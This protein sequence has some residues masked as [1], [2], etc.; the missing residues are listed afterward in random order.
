MGGMQWKR[1]EETV[2][3]A[4]WTAVLLVLGCE[5]GWGQN[6]QSQRPSQSSPSDLTQVSIE[7]LMNMEV[8]SVSKKEQKLSEV[9]AAIFVITPEDIRHSGATNIPDLLRM[10]PGLNVAQID[11]NTW[12][13]SARGFNFQ[14]AS[15]LL[16]LIDG[17]AVYT[18]LFGGVNWDTQNVPLEDIERIEVIRG[19]GGAV[20]GANAVNGVIN[21]I[22]KKA[23]ET[24]GVLVTGGGGTQALEFGTVQ[25]GGKITGNTNYRIFTSYQ[26][27]NHLPD[28]NGQNGEDDWHLLHG[29][30]RADTKL[31]QKDTLTTQGDM[32]TG[33]EGAI[34]VHAVFSPPDNVNVEK[35]VPLSGG[36]ILGRWNHIFSSRCDTTLQLYF[37]RYRRRGPNS[38]E[39]QDTIDFDFQNHVVLGRRQDLIWGAGFRH[40]SD[41]T[42]GTV[43]EAFVPAES[44]KQFFSLFLQDQITLKPSRIYLYVGTK[45]EDSYFTGFD[46][47][48]SVH[49]AW[50]PSAHRT[51]WAGISRASRTP[52]RRDVELDAALA[53]LPGPAELV[54]LGNPK[55]KSEHVIAYELGYRGQPTERF[56]IDVTAF[57]NTYHD[58]QSAD[59]LPPFIAPGSVPPLLVL[60]LLLDNKLH[61]T[62]DGVEAFIRWKVANHWTVS[63]GYSFLQMR[64][65]ND[66]TS[67]NT[68]SVAH[69]EASNP[70][71]QAQLR[72]HLELWRGFAWD[73]NAYFV[74]GLPAQMVASY[75][76]LDTQLTW[77]PMESVSLSVVGQNLLRD[78][79]VEF[80]DSFQS[81]NSSQ[82][83]RGAYAKLTWQF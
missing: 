9:A 67:F 17:R 13:I 32:Y 71:H 24:P 77:R 44:T 62:T 28:L 50:T 20:W 26:N 22:T 55:M 30:F 60:P 47:Q 53:A 83:K 46:L 54:L 68:T 7:N 64:L 42:E 43:D 73:A 10:V 16:V 61:G 18:P 52:T 48:P 40:A 8:T 11:S 82:V 27:N 63:P 23:E 51:F 76:R 66:P 37:D 39:D 36:N 59:R 34:I 1:T 41:D 21:I 69:A 56:S 5:V 72:S 74:G 38:S 3:R 35:F 6:P 57:V 81:V 80:N 75:T 14:F 12:A 70:G 19:P 49:L 31:S 79:H 25:Y 2:R 33:R 58:L 15:K 78:H 4:K 65:H 45:L 29:G